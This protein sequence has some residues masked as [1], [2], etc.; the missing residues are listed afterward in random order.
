MPCRI[1]GNIIA[2]YRGP[3]KIADCDEEGCNVRSSKL[4]D[5]GTGYKQTCDRRLCIYHA[6]K[7]GPNTDYCPEH[8]GV[9]TSIRERRKA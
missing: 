7:V 1:I 3:R 6:H 5:W 2:C 8:Y 4:C 9:W